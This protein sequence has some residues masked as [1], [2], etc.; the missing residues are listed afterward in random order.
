MPIDYVNM[1]DGTCN[2]ELSSRQSGT[3]TYG[4]PKVYA[5]AVCEQ[6]YIQVMP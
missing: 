3:T 6:E 5:I 2:K 1:F 4:P